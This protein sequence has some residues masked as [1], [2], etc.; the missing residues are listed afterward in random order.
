MAHFVVVSQ[1]AQPKVFTEK[2]GDGQWKIYIDEY[3]TLYEFEYNARDG[4]PGLIRV[5]KRKK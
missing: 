1:I 5:Y 3:F 2:T 4:I